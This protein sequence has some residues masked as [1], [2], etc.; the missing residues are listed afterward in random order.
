MKAPDGAGAAA[1]AQ[2]QAAIFGLLARVF[3]AAPAMELVEAMKGQAMLE[4]L[5]AC[6]LAFA[7]DFLTAEVAGL[8]ES[9]AQEYT[10]LFAGPG[11][12]IAAYESVYLP[13][14]GEHEP[15][16]WGAAAVAVAGFYRETGLELPEGRL[17]DHLAVEL[18][19]MAIMAGTEATSINEGD[20]AG[21]QRFAGLRERFCR[22][23][24]IRWV[25]AVCQD[26]QRETRS[27]FYKSMASLA[28]GL[29][30]ETCGEGNGSGDK[31]E[32]EA[33]NETT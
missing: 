14:D 10:R 25:P 15:R 3:E 16:L 32:E 24:L 1:I 17:P 18:E 30:E 22:E 33:L 29:I 9:L 8:V 21:A 26:V 5:E 13:G 28:A 12:Y 7:E 11:P 2:A 27:S 19:A 31:Q 6:G 4:S 20:K 23:H